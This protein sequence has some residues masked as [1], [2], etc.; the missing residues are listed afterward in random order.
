MKNFEFQEIGNNELFDPSIICADTPFTQASFYGDWQKSLGR[1]TR[2]FLVYSDKE[3][4]AYFQLIN[5]PL[6]LGKSYFY[7]PYGP[8]TKDFS[9][10]FFA[11]LKKEL[12][13][14]AKDD[15]AVFVRLDFTPPIANEILANFF[16]K[17]PFYTYHSAYFQPR[18]EW[19]LGLEKSEDELLKAMHEK[20]RY[21]IRLAEK[22]GI[23]AEIITQDF[24]K[25][26]EIFYTLMAGAAKRN[27]FNLHQKNYYQNIFQNLSKIDNSYLSI[28]SYNQK[29]LA[30]DLVI[31]FG[32]IANYVFGGSSDEYRNFCPSY[33]A[34]W[35]AIRNAKKIGCENYNFGGIMTAN[36][37]YRGWDG[38]TRFK[39]G[40]SGKEI[41][42]SDFF[43]VVVSPFWY[44]L[45]NFRKRIKKMKWFKK[46]FVFLA[47]A[48]LGLVS[49]FILFFSQQD[50][51]LPID[52]TSVLS[53]IEQPLKN[54]MMLAVPFITEAPDNNWVNPWINACEEAS[55]TMVEKFYQGE[56][57][58]SIA[59]AKEF[60]QM[61]FDVQNE[62]YGSN[63]NTDALRTAFLINNYTSYSGTIINNPTIEDI[64]K[65][66]G[67][68][69]PVITLHRGFDLENPNIPFLATGSSYHMLVIKGF[70]DINRQFITNDDGD[71]ESGNGRRYEYSLFMNSLHDYNFVDNLANGPARVIFTSPK[72]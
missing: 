38:L 16:T 70:D 35:L 30:I 1:K 21:S 5:Y 26:F 4:V 72:K 29:I 22:K 71:F 27:G 69:H 63:H 40:F 6:L 39:K 49:V 57:S 2:R 67:L 19:F 31:V 14:I 7:I 25:Y 41:N 46:D 59:E 15:K 47:L 45:Y 42:H 8:V 28:A 62:L 23:R 3:I 66:I 13:R 34:Q 55:I 10:D 68:G 12:I 64:K 11:N 9:K 24:E 58:T 56:E 18:S 48:I 65:E 53:T 61:L 37:I 43:D 36:K 51:I 52:T 17:A 33:S 32:K 60:M 20:T 44:H 50:T 54:N